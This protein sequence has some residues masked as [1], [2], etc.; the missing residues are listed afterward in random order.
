ML[1]S[2][3][4]I[5]IL[6]VLAAARRTE[7]VESVFREGG[8]EFRIIPAYA[9]QARYL[10]EVDPDPGAGAA[11]IWRERVV[12][13]SREDCLAGYYESSAKGRLSEPIRDLVRLEDA[14]DDLRGSTASRIVD[15]AL[16]KSAR[17]L[18]P[19]H[20]GLCF[21]EGEKMAASA[22]EEAAGVSGFTAG[23]G[24]ILLLLNSEGTR[25]EWT[26]Y[27]T[28][29]E[30]HHASRAHKR[31]EEHPEGE[32]VTD[33]ADYLIFEGRADSFARLLY[34]DKVPPWTRANPGG[35]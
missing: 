13:A 1:P 2:L 9:G 26:P 4:I 34:P 5:L 12:V 10:D 16:R 11:S 15:A 7:D 18:R 21:V 35:G 8:H 22:H 27:I 24:R 32:P 19:Q 31:P 28:A 29:H 33:L 20:R 23:S 3:P 14:V 6:V 17:R 30:Y 25:R